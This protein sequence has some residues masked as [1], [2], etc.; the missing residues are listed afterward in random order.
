MPIYSRRS[1]GPDPVGN[2]LEVASDPKKFQ[3]AKQEHL[4]PR[5]CPIQISSLPHHDAAV[6]VGP[7]NPCELFI[8][9]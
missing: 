7:Q 5:P 1:A 8:L 3:K 6:I 9:S 4:T 2:F